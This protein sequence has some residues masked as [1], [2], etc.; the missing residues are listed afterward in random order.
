LYW[1]SARNSKVNV[2]KEELESRRQTEEKI[3]LDLARQV[4]Y[5]Y[6]NM[7]AS[8]NVLMVASNSKGTSR[9]LVDMAEKE[10]KEGDISISDY[11]GILAV[12]S[13]ADSDY[14]IGKGYFYIWYQQLEQ[15]LGVRLDT[16]V[17]K[18]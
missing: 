3:K 8:H 5:E 13:K 4:I 2:Y 11:S 10:F 7:L 6:N 12:A 15:L 14:E 17:R 1:F 18:K 16:L 9:A